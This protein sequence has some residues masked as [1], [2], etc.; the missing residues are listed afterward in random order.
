MTKQQCKKL[1]NSLKKDVSKKISELTV[2]ALNSGALD[3]SNAD[4]RDFDYAKVILTVALET[5]SKKYQPYFA[6]NRKEM[7]NLRNFI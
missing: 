6:K 4:S 2:K 7:E 1:V 5:I 3:I